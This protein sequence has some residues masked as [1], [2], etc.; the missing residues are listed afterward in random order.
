MRVV[1]WFD[2]HFEES[3][4]V[5]LLIAICSVMM[6]QVV[7]RRVFNN[8][9]SWPEEFSRYCYVWTTFFSLAF[10]M[11]HGNMLRVS[12]VVDL[13]PQIVRKLVFIMG[14]LTCLIIFAVFFYNSIN[15]VQG[16]LATGQT[17]TA[18]R[19][20]MHL[21]YLCTVIGFG[22]AALRTVQVILKQIINFKVR[23]QTAIEAIKQEAEAEAA[24]AKSDLDK[25]LSEEKV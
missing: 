5:L 19:L 9:L 25:N 13:F 20:P 16:I 23:E 18:M 24:F 6:L 22:L 15:V 11:R 3:I 12:V 14:N 17:S 2:E 8:S 21:V 7:M 1:K 4:L 10:T